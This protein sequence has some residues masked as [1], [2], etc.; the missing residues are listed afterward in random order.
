RKIRVGPHKPLADLL[1]L[2]KA[3]ISSLDR[4]LRIGFAFPQDQRG[5]RFSVSIALQWNDGAIADLRLAAECAFQ[6]FGIDVQSLRHDDD[7]LLAPFEMQT[8][9]RIEFAEISGAEPAAFAQ[10]R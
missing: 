5:D 9:F 4:G 7:L 1:V 3:G 8:T 6:V 2:V 10:Y